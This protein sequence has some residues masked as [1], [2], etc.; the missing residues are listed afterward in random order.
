MKTILAMDRPSFWG[1]PP[2]SLVLD[3]VP[4]M[5]AAA[6]DRDIVYLERQRELDFEEEVERTRLT[7]ESISGVEIVASFDL[8]LDALRRADKLKWLHIWSAGID[9]LLYS[10]LVDH[11]VIITSAKGSGG[12]PMSEFAMFMML[13]WAKHGPHYLDAQ[14]DRRWDI[15][16][17]LELNGSTVGIIG[18]GN[19][20][21]DLAHKCKA[22]HMSVLGLRRSDT[23]CPDVDEM[24]THD[25][26]Q[27]FLEQCDFVVVTTP[28]TDET[29]GLL[30][31]AEFKTMK[32]S[33]I[34]IVTSRG[35]VAD[36]D[37]LLKALNEGWI[38]G[39][40]PWRR[41]RQ[42]RLDHAG[43]VGHGA[44]RLHR[45]RRHRLHEARH[46]RTGLR[47]QVRDARRRL[48][49]YTGARRDQRGGL[50]VVRARSP[51]TRHR[52]PRDTAALPEK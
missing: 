45:G 7:A 39:A 10:E 52:Q 30:G 32:S 22:F 42:G 36:D 41:I 25:R 31:E 19:S 26:I 2:M 51:R 9:H 47:H 48:A 16:H 1:S 33:A 43:R 37:A 50:R 38:A 35:G 49:E 5:Q 6:P 46:G 24:Y 23:P 15:K 29:R 44:Y 12:I 11:P 34:F 17:N 28:V 13:M 27:Q 20:G 18:L 40:H 8:G 14:Q 3:M 4:D 21:A